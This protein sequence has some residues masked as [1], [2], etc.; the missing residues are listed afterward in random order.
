[1]SFRSNGRSAQYAKWN[2]A[3]KATGYR[4]QYEADIAASLTTQ[5]VASC[6]EPCRI[7]YTVNVC[8]TYKPDWTLPDQAIVLEAKGEFSK[9]DRDKM[10]IIKAQYQHLDIR[11][12]FQNPNQ[13][14]AGR[15]TC[16]GW[17]DRHGFKWCKGP[18]LPP[19]WITHKPGVRSRKAF[20]A[21]AKAAEAPHVVPA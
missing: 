2:A 10:M 14:V 19:D 13:K 21:V 7:P 16:A 8:A 17:A 5:G 4:S 3:R 15:Q 18:A 9:A 11:F 20:D 6:Y 12:M 1:M